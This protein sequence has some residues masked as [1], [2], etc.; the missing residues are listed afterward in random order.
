MSSLDI[1]C[2]YIERDKDRFILLWKS[3]EKFLKIDN[4]RLFLVSASGKSPIK[5]S[6]LIPIKEQDLDPNICNKRYQDQG[7][8]KQ[9]II[10]LLAH[11]L[12]ST[13]SILS[14]D[15]DCFLNKNL[16]YKNIC[17]ND[18]P[19]IRV[20]LDGSWENWYR[21]SESLLR[22]NWKKKDKVGVTP[23]IFSKTILSALDK[24]LT[25]L[26]GANK[27]SVLLE[28]SQKAKS[29]NISEV[30]TE[31]CLY[32][33]YADYTGMLHKY[34]HL[35]SDFEL[36]DNCF[37]NE[38]EADNWDPSLSFN[39]PKHFF[40]VAQSVANKPALWVYEKIKQY[41]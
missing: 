39:D 3:L 19:K 16:Y 2:P 24:Y 5:S 34:H 27:T 20:T 10:K 26:Y 30:W 15:C 18:K 12:C 32:H 7:W 6:N 40:T 38:K 11:K 21:G 33:I 31:Y 37:W 22:M 25:V 9:Q 23:F 28:H 35:D 1:I 8:W 13:E 4:Y 14:V 29:A 36:Y 17:S 41:L